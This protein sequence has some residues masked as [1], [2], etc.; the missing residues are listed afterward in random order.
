MGLGTLA[1]WEQG[2]WMQLGGIIGGLCI[3]ALMVYQH[4]QLLDRIDTLDSS[5]FLASVGAGVWVV[6]LGAL[7]IIAGGIKAQPVTTPETESD[8]A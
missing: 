8:S 5:G 3:A 6:Y 7:L 1:G 2:N 4:T